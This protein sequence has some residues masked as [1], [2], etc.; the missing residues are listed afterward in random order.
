MFRQLFSVA[1]SLFI[2]GHGTLI[3]MVL[4]KG[5]RLIH[6]VGTILYKQFTWTEQVRKGRTLAC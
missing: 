2:N 5:A 1:L 3:N 4:K 6:K